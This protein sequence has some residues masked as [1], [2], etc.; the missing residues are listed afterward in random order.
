MNKKIVLFG[1][2]FIMLLFTNV[3]MAVAPTLSNEVPTD[4][5]TLWE[6]STTSI[7]VTIKDI[8]T[9]F[10]YTIDT[11]PDIGNSSGFNVT[12][13]SKTCSISGLAYST[14]YTWTINASDFNGTG[15]INESY[16]FTTRDAKLRENDE[17]TGVEK[18]IVGA[19]GIL[20]LLGFIYVILN[21][22]FKKE[23]NLAK[24]LVGIMLALIFLGVIFSAL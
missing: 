16:T 10:N 22:D 5:S 23:G 2:I 21:M 9:N 4:A 24:L 11:S 14:T 3:A 19:V 17:F 20:I 7:N 13:G 6:M 15:Y 8:D 18:A 1:L 12:N